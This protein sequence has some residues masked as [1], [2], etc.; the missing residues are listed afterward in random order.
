V[1][2]CDDRLLIAPQAI[3]PLMV[4]LDEARRSLTVWL[5]KAAGDGPF[6]IERLTAVYLP[7]WL[8]EVGGVV[9]WSALH[10]GGVWGIEND[11]LSGT[12]P[13]VSPIAV[14]ACSKPRPGSA[15][16]VESTDPRLLVAFDPAYL[17]AL[18]A[19]TYTLSMANAALRARQRALRMTG[20]KLT[21]GSGGVQLS[22]RSARMVV[23]S[24]LLA[25]APVWLADVRF[26]ETRRLLVVSG[27]TARVCSEER[28]P[29]HFTD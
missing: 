11:P 8:F 9:E 23:T 16:A 19:E 21:A 14:L 2:E 4:S 12:E 7:L 24:Y 13:P 3:V 28:P 22:L 26:G 1:E 25:L 6:V 10:A 18:P 27:V 15:A 29:S 17:A 5:G 20:E